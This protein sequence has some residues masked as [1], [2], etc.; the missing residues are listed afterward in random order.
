MI[1]GERIIKLYKIDLNKYSLRGIS[2]IDEVILTCINEGLKKQKIN[3]KYKLNEIS[4]IEIE[5]IKYYLFVHNYKEHNSDWADFL[6]G[7]L[8][9]TNIP[10]GKEY[11]L[12]L[13]IYDGFR[14]LCSIGGYAYPIVVNFI[15]HS[16]GL[17]LLSKI[18]NPAEDEI[19]SISSR[20]ITG[21]LSGSQ[22][23]YRASFKVI[24]YIRFGRVPTEI[25]LR[26]N[27]N[28]S[29]EFFSFTKLDIDNRINLYAGKYFSL[30]QK[31]SFLQF[32]QLIKEIGFINELDAE[33]YLNSYTQI[34]DK[35]T[36][37]LWDKLLQKM[38]E[39]LNTN[40]HFFDIAN[41]KIRAFYEAKDYL[42]KEKIG[43]RKYHLFRTLQ[44]RSRI[45]RVIQDRV[46]EIKKDERFEDFKYYILGLKLYANSPDY[47]TPLKG[48]FIY[49]IDTE[50]DHEGSVYFLISGKWFKLRTRFV[51]DLKRQ[52]ELLMGQ[53][54][55]AN[56]YMHIPW[57]KELQPKESNY[58]L[59]YKDL[60]NYFVLDTIVPDH[61]ELCDILYVNEN[62]TYLIHVK[63][64]FTASIRELANQ[65]EIAAKR[66][67]DDRAT[68]E[69]KYLK[70]VHK[71]YSNK[72]R[73]LISQDDFLRFFDI[74]RT[75]VFVMAFA[76]HLKEPV[77]I[78][79]NSN[80]YKSN[81]A[82]YSMITCVRS[83]QSY[84]ARVEICQIK[85]K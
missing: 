60:D 67:S 53:Y 40:I 69:K 61:I 56:S 72:N 84:N 38:Y 24:D 2:S 5:G 20:G 47:K 26:L 64:G 73:K 10:K 11:A 21:L 66:L 44:D 59:N 63:Y 8:L 41:E 14:L 6:P 75:M 74:N 81:I 46:R 12:I 17:T 45:W 29:K 42:L 51:E 37:I 62:T 82:K 1:N 54:L 52:F 4:K 68:D 18:M 34:S 15:D 65:V 50:M 70:S 80:V 27:S 35:K 9:K 77:D 31:L 83:M 58:N 36:E 79:H 33:D 30:K 3:Q 57:D 28:K 32:Q 16:F 48:N 78:R 7:N 22:Q 25:H 71:A 49:Q 55:I 76:S 13:F 19:L 23:Q 43:T 85:R 39:S